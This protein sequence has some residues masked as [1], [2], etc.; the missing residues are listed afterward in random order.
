MFK[1]I[2]YSS[3][4]YEKVFFYVNV[5]L[6]MFS[7]SVLLSARV[8]A[9][10]Q[11]TIVTNQFVQEA[12]NAGSN[13]IKMGEIGRQKAQNAKVRDYAAMILKDHSAANAEL[14]TLAISKNIALAD[15]NSAKNSVHKTNDSAVRDTAMRNSGHGHDILMQANPADFDAQYLQMMVDDHDEAIAL[16][17]KGSKVADPDIKAFA[18]KYLPTLRKHL[19]EA[20]A[21]S[22]IYGET[23]KGQGSN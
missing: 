18:V 12:A 3:N 21:L 11:D 9:R 20:V 10:Q 1:P 4:S 16:F 14:K 2:H 23:K 13:E 5:I 17:E 22:K 15:S 8:M 6:M 19:N 7:L